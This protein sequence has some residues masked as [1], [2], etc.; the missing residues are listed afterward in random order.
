MKVAIADPSDLDRMDGL[1]HVLPLP[2]EFVI[3]PG[4]E[5]QRAV[6]RYYPG[7]GQGRQ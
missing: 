1:S 7:Q 5:I 6:A 3:A 4:E 2:S